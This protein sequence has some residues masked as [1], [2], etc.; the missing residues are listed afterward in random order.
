MNNT[1]TFSARVGFCFTQLKCRGVFLMSDKVFQA[2]EMGG[3]H[4][5]AE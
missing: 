5:I 2:T 1:F 4:A 3:I